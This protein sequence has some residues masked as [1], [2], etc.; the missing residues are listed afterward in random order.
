MEVLIEIL[1]TEQFDEWMLSLS[2]QE[3]KA[4]IKKMEKLE[5]YGAQL[6]RP[7]V[8]LIEHSEFP[9]MKE[10]RARGT[11]RAFFAIDPDRKAIILIG[12][13]KEGDSRFYKKYIKQADDLYRGYLASKAEEKV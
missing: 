3:Q 13:D 2:R 10:L 9:N 11:L 8:D 4:I 6:G 5:V 1:T 7:D 12:G